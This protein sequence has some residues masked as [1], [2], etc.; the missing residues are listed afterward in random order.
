MN[1]IRTTDLEIQLLKKDDR[2][3]WIVSE[4]KKT[5]PDKTVIKD[6]WEADLCAIGLADIDEKYLIYISTY[7][8]PNQKL[9][10]I[11]ED[12]GNDTEQ[13]KIIGEYKNI[14]LNEL[15]NILTDIM[16]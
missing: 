12:L 1:G 2:V 8:L 11:I 7:G 14:S 3:K 16:E 15:K 10:L 13:T 5:F 4:L 9:D 6:C